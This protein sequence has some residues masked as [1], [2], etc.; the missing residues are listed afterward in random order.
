MMKTEGSIILK[1]FKHETTHTFH[2]GNEFGIQY[3]GILGR[4]FFEDKQG[5]I[6]YCD[7]Q[8]TMGDIVVKFDPKD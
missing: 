3:D 7:Q 8:I 1:L 5:I 4:D 2:V 6:N